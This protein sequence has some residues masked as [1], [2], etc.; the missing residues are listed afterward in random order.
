[1][2]TVNRSTVNQTDR[3]EE[4]MAISIKS[5]GSAK[6]ASRKSSTKSTRKPAGTQNKRAATRAKGTTK[7]S[8]SKAK[9]APESTRRSPNPQ[10]SQR[11]LDKLLKPL[12]RSAAKRD[13]LNEQWKEAV[14]E[15]N[16]AIVAAVEGGAPVNLVVENG[17]IS[18]QHVYFLMQQAQS[19]GRSNGSGSKSAGRK[20]ASKAKGT[21]RK[22]GS[23]SKS[24]RKSPAKR[25]GSR[26]KI[27]ARS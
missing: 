24:T 4:T 6:P 5:K 14:Q 26:P 19:G 22:S 8:T 2:N 27:R 9:P 23:A 21:T 25:G 16:E 15:A 11:E 18:R 17:D 20:A 10:I 12:S 13:K 1:L 3:Q 7:R